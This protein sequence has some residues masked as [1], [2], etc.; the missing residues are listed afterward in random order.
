MPF[1]LFPDLFY[2]L[3]LFTVE[4]VKVDIFV[5]FLILEGKCSF[6]PLNVTFPRGTDSSGRVFDIRGW[7]SKYIAPHSYVSREIF[8]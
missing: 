5:L 8:D 7:S 2:W 3:K 1:S 6:L 4:V